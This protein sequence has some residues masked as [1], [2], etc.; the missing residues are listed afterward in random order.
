MRLRGLDQLDHPHAGL[1]VR[2]PALGV[3][4]DPA[5]PG[6]LEEHRV[7]QRAERVGV[8]AGAL[9]GDAQAVVAGEGDPRDDVVG[10]LGQHDRGGAVVDREDEAG[11]GLRVAGVAGGEGRAGDARVER[12]DVGS[13]VG[14][15]EHGRTLVAFGSRGI[16]G[17]PRTTPPTPPADP[18]GV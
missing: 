16:G 17:P 12:L 3:D 9:G 2:G 14:G 5:H 7:L 6:G 18:L 13:D 8:V 1:D 11:A 10:G 4:L 15:G